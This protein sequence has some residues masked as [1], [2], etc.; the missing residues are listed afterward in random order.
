[1]GHDPLADLA[2]L[3]GQDD[4]FIERRLNI[5]QIPFK[6][7]TEAQGPVFAYQAAGST[8]TCVTWLDATVACR[9]SELLPFRSEAEG[10]IEIALLEDEIME[11][12]SP[13]MDGGSMKYQPPRR[14]TIGA[15]LFEMAH[16][17]NNEV[18]PE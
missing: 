8:A 10:A 18:K 14:S 17:W 7:H 6:Y 13:N 2:R 9:H 11:M 15:Y 16:I 1:M 5:R 3:I 12:L 4:P